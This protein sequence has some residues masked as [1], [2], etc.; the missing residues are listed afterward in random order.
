MLR[1][2]S[3][4]PRAGMMARRYIS[5]GQR[6]PKVSGLRV[7]RNYEVEETD[8]DKLFANKKVVVFGLPGACPPHAEA[9]R[10]H[11]FI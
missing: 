3:L 7:V 11:A 8:S 6:V 10:V 5:A 4:L 1:T 9:A 2:T